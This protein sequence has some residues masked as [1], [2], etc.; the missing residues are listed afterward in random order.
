MVSFLIIIVVLIVQEQQSNGHNAS[1]GYTSPAW[2]SGNL[3]CFDIPVK[4]EF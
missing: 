4:F 3:I 2:R 1:N